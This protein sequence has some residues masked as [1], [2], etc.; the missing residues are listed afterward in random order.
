MPS[1]CATSLSF[2]TF[3][4]QSGQL[5]SQNWSQEQ[6]HIYLYRRS[7]FLT[8]SLRNLRLAQLFITSWLKVVRLTFGSSIM[9]EKNEWSIK[10]VHDHLNF[11]EF[12]AVQFDNGCHYR[13]IQTGVYVSKITLQRGL[14]WV[15][16]APLLRSYSKDIV[17]KDL[18]NYHMISGWR[19]KHCIPIRRQGIVSYTYLDGIRI[20]DG[21]IKASL[22]ESM[23][24]N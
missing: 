8:I 19:D 21:S 12:G 22:D 15:G 16:M 4:R 13:S 18:D 11:F 17:S 9:A 2:L 7:D 20:S 14:L 1:K 6:T 5:F 24:R 10:S 3:I 23:T